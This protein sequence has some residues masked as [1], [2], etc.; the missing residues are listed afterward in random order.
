[1]GLV[2]FLL[3]L[4]PG[5]RQKDNSWEKGKPRKSLGLACTGGV[6]HL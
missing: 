1:M 3:I 2:C 5:L 4:V 6:E